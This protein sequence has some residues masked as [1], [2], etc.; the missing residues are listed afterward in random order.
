[1]NVHPK[2]RFAIASYGLLVGLGSIFALGAGWY[3]FLVSGAWIA[4]FLLPVHSFFGF[5]LFYALANDRPTAI[6]PA[7]AL[8]VSSLA[9][10]IAVLIFS[11]VPMDSPVAITLATIAIS[12]PAV[13]IY[14]LL[15]SAKSTTE[16]IEGFK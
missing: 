8:F 3:G 11:K 13:I 10:C 5:W 6:Y 16:N 14:Y 2:I 9:Y 1:M 4:F 15:W 12:F 7:A